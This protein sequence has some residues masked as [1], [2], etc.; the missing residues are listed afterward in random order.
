M[1]T[2]RLCT[3]LAIVL[4]CSLSYAP[5]PEGMSDFFD[6]LRSGDLSNFEV[7]SDFDEFDQSGPFFNLKLNEAF[8]NAQR[9]EVERYSK[10]HIDPEKIRNDLRNDLKRFDVPPQSPSPPRLFK[11]TDADIFARGKLAGETKVPPGVTLRSDTA[12]RQ[13]YNRLVNQFSQ[14]VNPLA[15]A[16]SPVAPDEPSIQRKTT[17]SQQNKR[18]EQRQSEAF[19]LWRESNIRDLEAK[20]GL[21]VQSALTELSQTRPDLYLRVADQDPVPFTSTE[22]TQI[23]PSIPIGRKGIELLWRGNSRTAVVTK[24]GYQFGS[25]G[26]LP[27]WQPLRALLMLKQKPPSMKTLAWAETWSERIRYIGDLIKALRHQNIKQVGEELARINGLDDLDEIETLDEFEKYL[28]EMGGAG[29]SRRGKNQQTPLLRDADVAPARNANPTSDRAIFRISGEDV[30]NLTKQDSYFATKSTGLNYS[31]LKPIKSDPSATIGQTIESIAPV[32]ANQDG[33][34]SIP[35]NRS[36]VPVQA[37]AVTR[38]GKV[39]K[40]G[41]DYEIMMAPTGETFLKL[42]GKKFLGAPLAVALDATRG[43]NASTKQTPSPKPLDKKVLR[44]IA[45]SMKEQGL[46]ALSEKLDGILSAK[47]PVYL[48]TLSRLIEENTLY[49]YRPASLP[50]ADRDRLRLMETVGMFTAGNYEQFKHLLVPFEGK[51]VLALQCVDSAKLLQEMLKSYSKLKPEAPIASRIT[52]GYRAEKNGENW[53]LHEISHAWVEAGEPGEPIERLDP[54]TS[55][56]DP[57]SPKQN[58]FPERGDFLTTQQKWALDKDEEVLATWARIQRQMQESSAR[59][60]AILD[61]DAREF[62]SN[63]GIVAKLSARNHPFIQVAAVLSALKKLQTGE[64]KGAIETAE[65]RLGYERSN[66]TTGSNLVSFLTKKAREL[67]EL[68]DSQ[69]KLEQFNSDLVSPQR[70]TARARLAVAEAQALENL[71]SVATQKL[72]RASAPKSFCDAFLRRVARKKK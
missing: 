1:S 68:S 59:I 60:Q 33:L 15:G 12:L 69:L 58:A 24:E 27:E 5:D 29:G 37:R 63:R 62:E 48:S 8:W 10:S 35:L 42:L 50:R 32:V 20:L 2:L 57:N 40:E 44:Q 72:N 66:Q 14:D 41:S 43:P 67:A 52:V 65:R 47:K 71:L 53:A 55:R 30:P 64:V 7:D 45:K 13:R 21:I 28:Q 4:C 3:A 70:Y 26:W 17:V 18:S 61:R 11:D 49:T 34:I 23:Q 19:D 56:L 25:L 51:E 39:L 6:R 31:D 22:V 16:D 9:V 38:E 36:S 46:V 54:T